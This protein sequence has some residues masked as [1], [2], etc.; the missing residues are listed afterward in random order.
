[1]N[2]YWP[3]LRTTILLF[4]LNIVS[5]C[6]TMSFVSYMSAYKQDKHKGKTIVVSSVID[7][8]GEEVKLP[9]GACLKFVKE[10]RIKHGTIVGNDTRIKAGKSVIFEDVVVNGDWNVSNIYSE[11][12][13]SSSNNNTTEI[14]NLFA[15]C[16]GSR[17]NKVYIQ[18]RVYSI[19]GYDEVSK[20]AGVMY[21]P[22]NTEIHNQASFK[23]LLTSSDKSFPFYFYNVENCLWEG[24]VIEGD[25][26]THKG[27][28]G[29]QGF[30]IAIR[31]SRNITIRDVECNDCWGDGI[32]LQYS[33]KGHNKDI[34]IE[35]V[36]CSGN[37]R[38]G[39]SIEDGINVTVRNSI[40]KDTGHLHGT[41]PMFG[42]DIEPAYESAKLQ[43]ILI[44]GCSF[45]N[46]KGGGVSIS[47]VKQH[48]DNIVVKNCSD[49]SGMQITNV[50]LDEA[51]GPVIVSNYQSVG[52]LM[53][54]KSVNNILIERSRFKSLLTRTKECSMS[55]VSINKT[56]FETD[57]KRTW[58][59]Y[60][61]SLICAETKDVM[62][63]N[64][65]F[66]ILDG[67]EL[68][69][70]FASGGDWSGVTIS[71]SSICDHRESTLY[72]PCDVNNCTIDSAKGIAFVNCKNTE[73]NFLNNTIRIRNYKGTPYFVFHPSKLQE[74]RVSNNTVS[75][76]SNLDL[77]NAM[78]V[79][80]TN[81]EKPIVRYSDKR[82]RS[83]KSST[84]IIIKH[85]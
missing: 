83:L 6:S 57:E 33:S 54:N 68:T 13:S 38:Q 49:D 29:E 55:H 8:N 81:K 46:N 44:E 3:L 16:S 73:L 76:D 60:A 79:Y 72:I 10:G 18:N 9:Q 25:L 17:S 40:F 22:S 58:N 56:V 84:N 12:L 74:Y 85:E 21:I 66:N 19:D 34:I 80:K 31:S 32:N 50:V 5:S 30:G 35:D 28:T 24:G 1:M 14:K 59:Y 7:L 2:K 69:S 45:V 20:S 65:S 82:N 64:C 52:K 61:I 4:L 47:S 42:I 11:W 36:T 23:I 53:F 67:S 27:T 75:S 39:I 41:S 63:D 15:L 26:K 51:S 71:N 70:V 43:N 37:R 77:E 62:F 48:G 78:G